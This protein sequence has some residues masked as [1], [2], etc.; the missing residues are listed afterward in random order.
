[1]NKPFAAAILAGTLLLNAPAQAEEQNTAQFDPAVSTLVQSL[2]DHFEAVSGKP[3]ANDDKQRLGKGMTQSFNDNIREGY[4][5][6]VTYRI[7]REEHP[8]IAHGNVCR[9]NNEFVLRP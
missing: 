5:R 7:W 4:C 3:L 6:T 1:M 2:S 9:I 8:L